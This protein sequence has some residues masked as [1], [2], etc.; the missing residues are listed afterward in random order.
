MGKWENLK[1]NFNSFQNWRTDASMNKLENHFQTQLIFLQIL[2]GG[3][4][5]LESSSNGRLKHQ[6][7]L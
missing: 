6:R 3:P 4:T 1:K 7:S 5:Q 2:G